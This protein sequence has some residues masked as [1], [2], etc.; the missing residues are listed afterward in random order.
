MYIPPPTERH[1]QDFRIL[2]WWA[3]SLDT[4]IVKG[5]EP[6]MSRLLRSTSVISSTALRCYYG[7]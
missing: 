1:T 5:V 6:F 7:V 2:Y 3:Q 4:G